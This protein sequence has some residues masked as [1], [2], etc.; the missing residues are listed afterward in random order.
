[1]K[2]KQMTLAA[3][4]G[5]AATSVL[6]A[7]TINV[8]AAQ[9]R[10]PWNN[11]VDVKYTLDGCGTDASKYAVVLTTAI[12]GA[13]VELSNGAEPSVDGTHTVACLLPSDLQAK[14]CKITGKVYEMAN[15]TPDAGDASSNNDYMIVDLTT[16]AVTYEAKLSYQALSN[17]RYN[18][19]T[20]KTTKMVFRKVPAGTYKVN[21]STTAASLADVALDNV[22]TTKAYYIGIFPVTAG[23]YTL[24]QNKSASV[25]ATDANKT[26]QVS[27]SWDTIRG[28]GSQAYSASNVTADPT[29][30]SPIGT[31][32]KNTSLKFDLPTDLMWEIAYRAGTTTAYYWGDNMEAMG[33]SHLFA[34]SGNTA[35]GYSAAAPVGTKRPNA[36]GLYDVSGNVWEWCRDQ[37]SG[38]VWKANVASGKSLSDYVFTPFTGGSST[39]CSRRG[40][41]WDR[42]DA[43]YFTGAYRGSYYP[44]YTNASL[45]F[46]LARIVQ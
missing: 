18:A 16:G 13:E 26:P 3:A 14:G 36:W 35:G 17:R 1:M 19:D 20:Y 15:C 6:A 5:L 2:L 27:I 46:R 12:G 9:Q 29:T 30:S 7:P 39:N 34:V 11:I 22:T 42:T 25:T 45:G 41:S 4:L 32:N 10:Y 38:G 28:F 24:M 31:M 40:G 23:Q 21:A 33:T 44:N 8:T 43:D 37:W